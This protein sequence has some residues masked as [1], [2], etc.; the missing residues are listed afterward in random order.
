MY[1][2][3]REATAGV[4]T[5]GRTM[6]SLAITFSSDVIPYEHLGIAGFYEVLR[7]LPYKKDPQ[8]LELVKRPGFT[9]S[10]I[11]PG[12]DC[13]DKAV[14]MAAMLYRLHIPFRFL[15]GGRQ[16][17]G[18]LHHVWVQGYVNGRWVDMD[19]TYE[20]NTLGSR[21]GAWPRQEIIG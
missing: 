18:P 17:T 5:T 7:K 9:L 16:K 21:I 10:S 1:F 15:A 12:G 4:H 11:G 8:G 14:A 6:R 20:W 13:D 19:P 2:M 3:A